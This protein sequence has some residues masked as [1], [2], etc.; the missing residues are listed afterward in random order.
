MNE[1]ERIQAA[2]AVRITGLSRR[3]IQEM[4]ARGEIPGA[5]KLGARWTFDEAKLRR[6][7]KAREEEGCRGISTDAAKSGG[8]ESRFA[9]ATFAEAYEQLLR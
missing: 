6:W 3:A 7:V 5:A 2:A 8:R 4:A 1:S 9:A